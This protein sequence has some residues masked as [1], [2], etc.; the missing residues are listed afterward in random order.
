[1]K[2]ITP[3]PWRGRY[4][5]LEVDG[6]AIATDCVDQVGSN[7]WI[8][9]DSLVLLEAVKR[10][11]PVARHLDI[12][13]GTGVIALASPAKEVTAID[14][15]HRA[16]DFAIWNAKMNGKVIHCKRQDVFTMEDAPYDLIT[17][18]APFVF[19]PETDR[20]Y[21]AGYGGHLGIEVTLRILERLPK[22]L[23]AT[24][25]A[26]LLTASPIL[27]D[28]TDALLPA[29]SRVAKAQG[30][31]ITMT[32]DVSYWDTYRR[33]FHRQHR[34]SHFTCML[35]TVERGDGMVTKYQPSLRL[36]LTTA[37]RKWWNG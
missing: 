22:M 37:A 1:M 2:D 4:R 20:A 26:L 5:L 34:I 30:L 10:E 17:W 9:T 16:I 32:P 8:G 23:T 21:H 7:V 35:L 33:D 29:L 24:G 15:N 13:T 12:G 14:I 19:L 31:N 28:G 27:M 11:T 3:G 6:L 36:R 18:N 25:R